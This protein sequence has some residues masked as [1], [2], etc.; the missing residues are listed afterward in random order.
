MNIPDTPRNPPE[1][2]VRRYVRQT[3]SYDAVFSCGQITDSY[4]RTGKNQDALTEISSVFATRLRTI[5]RCHCPRGRCNTSLVT[6][7]A[8]PES[9]P[10][11]QVRRSILPFP[12]RVAITNRRGGHTRETTARDERACRAQKNEMNAVS[13]RSCGFRA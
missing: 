6:A 12:S 2:D 4:V 1:S 3:P 5:I 10:Y 11:A 7:P 8:S 13:V 9:A